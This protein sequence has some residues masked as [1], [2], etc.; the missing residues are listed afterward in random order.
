MKTVPKGNF[1]EHLKRLLEMLEDH[2]VDIGDREILFYD[3]SKIINGKSIGTLTSQDLIKRDRAKVLF[4][5]LCRQ[6]KS[7]IDLIAKGVWRD[8]FLVAI[9]FSDEVLRQPITNVNIVGLPLEASGPLQKSAAVNV[10]GDI[11]R[12]R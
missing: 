4:D 3:E 1:D 5:Y 12:W 6:G 7:Q 8:Y 9:K 2:G 10:V 11:R